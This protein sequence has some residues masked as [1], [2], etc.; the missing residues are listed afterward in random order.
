M[1]M[2][3]MAGVLLA[4]AMLLVPLHGHAAP[5]VVKFSYI[6]NEDDQMD[7]IAKKAKAYIEEKTNGRYRIDLLCCQKMGSE[8]AM[9]TAIRTGA[10]QIMIVSAPGQLDPMMNMTGVPYTIKDKE[11]FYKVYEGPVGKEIAE[12]FGQVAGFTPV[13]WFYRI[14]QMIF[15]TKPLT[16]PEDWAKFKIRAASN[17][18]YTSQLDAMGA[19][20]VP[21]PFPEVYMA[22]KTGVID[23]VQTV[24]DWF[25]SFKLYEVCKYAIDIKHD[26]SPVG[27]YLNNR[28]MNSLSEEDRAVFIEAFSRQKEE[29]EKWVDENHK[30]Y[31][32]KMIAEGVQ[33]TV[34]SDEDIA[35]YKQLCWD[36]LRKNAELCGGTEIMEKMFEAGGYSE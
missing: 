4:A 33:V 24:M 9:G 21:M 28:F 16:K 10:I 1:I 13:Y 26:F 17:F 23:G 22:L 12:H 29:N 35:K 6:Q 20:V 27:V 31:Y 2:K 8:E 14:H 19:R 25:V 3:R 7:V 15:T 36:F 5:K 34:A 18:A 30:R 32:D 11:H